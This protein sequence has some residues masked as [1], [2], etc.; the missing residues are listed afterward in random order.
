MIA[1]PKALIETY[2][3]WRNIEKGMIQIGTRERNV[4]ATPVVR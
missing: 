1:P 4:D 3:L 2:S